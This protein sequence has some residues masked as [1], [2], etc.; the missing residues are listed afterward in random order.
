MDVK[1]ITTKS[2]TIVNDI[3]KAFLE[4]NKGNKLSIEMIQGL[5]INLNQGL[6]QFIAALTS[7][8]EPPK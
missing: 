2:T 5:A 4:N 8:E 1:E 7:T 3:L 6:N